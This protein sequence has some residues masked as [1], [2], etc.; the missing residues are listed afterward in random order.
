MYRK[1]EINILSYLTMYVGSFTNFKL[2][3]GRKSNAKWHSFEK[4]SSTGMKASFPRNF[5]T[6]SIFESSSKKSLD[7]LCSVLKIQICAVC[8]LQSLVE[9]SC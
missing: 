6:G 4:I 3:T 1:S 7:S 8:A 5:A 2:L 9:K